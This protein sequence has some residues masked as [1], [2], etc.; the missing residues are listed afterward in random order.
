MR[1]CFH[2]PVR[3]CGRQVQ[4]LTNFSQVLK[5]FFSWHSFRRR[6]TTLQNPREESLDYHI[7][8][9][10]RRIVD[11]TEAA[12]S[13]YLYSFPHRMLITGIH[14]DHGT[15]AALLKSCICCARQACAPHRSHYTQ[16]QQSA[17]YAALEACG[18]KCER[19]CGSALPYQAQQVQ[20]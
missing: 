8:H 3:M 18:G 12:G 17:G 2:I 13:F 10:H 16:L 6:A 11:C 20:H 1:R 19:R 4:Q 5:L 7:I 14:W 15:S 9:V